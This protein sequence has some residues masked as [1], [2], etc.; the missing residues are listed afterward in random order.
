MIKE[1]LF[2]EKYKDGRLLCTLCPRYC[3]IGDG[4]IGFCFVRQNKDGKLWSLAYGKPTAVHIDPVEKKPLNH[5]LPG[6]SIL[7]LGTAGCNMG[8]KFCQNWDMSKARV[9][10]IHSMDVTPHSVVDLAT[11]NHCPSIA[12][13]YNEP[14]IFAEF[15]MDIARIA[16]EKGIYNVMVTNGYIT[17]EALPLVYENIDGANVD[18]KAFSDDFYRKWTLSRIEPVLKSLVAMKR[19][20]V[21]IEITTLLIPGLNDNPSEIKELSRWVKQNL[22]EEVPIHFTAFHPDYKLLDRPRTPF[23]TIRMA[24]EIARSEGIKFVYEGNILSDGNNTYCPSCERVLIERVWHSISIRDLTDD[25]HCPCGEK[26]P[27]FNPFGKN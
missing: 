16:H 5:F 13:T 11:K 8:C 21:W 20:G 22:G 2:W 6:T 26:I 27:F 10:Q 24:R 1:A 3:K 17:E 18:L 9:D 23:K 4:K 12:F 14:T 25:N 7:S 15:A 19:L